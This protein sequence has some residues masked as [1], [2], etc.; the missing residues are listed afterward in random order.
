MPH[1]IARH[2]NGVDYIHRD[3]PDFYANSEVISGV[4]KRVT[5]WNDGPRN[6]FHHKAE[7]YVPVEHVDAFVATCYSN[8]H[9]DTEAGDRAWDHVTVDD[10]LSGW[11]D[12]QEH[13]HDEAG[14]NAA[15]TLPAVTA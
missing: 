13:W 15:A 7:T 3:H 14:S 2:P 10:D 12:P 8:Q 11:S 5:C 1:M 6:G 9:R 4:F